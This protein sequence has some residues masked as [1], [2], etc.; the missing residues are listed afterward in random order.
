MHLLNQLAELEAKWRILYLPMDLLSIA[1]L[2]AQA[3]TSTA[4]AQLSTSSFNWTPIV[5]AISGALVSSTV[6]AALIKHW[7]DGRLEKQ[8]QQHQREMQLLQAEHEQQL[9]HERSKKINR[10]ELLK[11][12]EAMLSVTHWDRLNFRNSVP[13][14]A[15]KLYIQD[16]QIINMMDRRWSG[17]DEVVL[18]SK[19]RSLL[20][21]EIARLK[22]EWNLL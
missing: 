15:L 4:Q 11:Q 5:S 8:R 14:E 3:Q 22:K 19:L 6:V 1:H 7:S 12:C 21:Q 10:E 9:E 18:K 16:E 2:L 13:Y 20:R 17:S